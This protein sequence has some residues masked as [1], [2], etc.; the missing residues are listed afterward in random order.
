LDVGEGRINV[1]GLRRGCV[2]ARRGQACCSAGARWPVWADEGCVGGMWWALRH[3][4]GALACA[5]DTVACGALWCLEACAAGA[6][7]AASGE[8]QT[9]RVLSSRGCVT[10]A[11]AA[12]R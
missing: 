7:R 10:V 3:R 12:G 8:P 9:A 11:T 4:A 5:V 6:L 1:T 2:F